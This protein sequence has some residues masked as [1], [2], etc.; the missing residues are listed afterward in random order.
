[1]GRR[2]DARARACAVDAVAGADHHRLAAGAGPGRQGADRRRQPRRG[3]VADLP[4]RAAGLR[5]VRARVRRAWPCDDEGPLPEALAAERRGARF[6]YLL[7]N[8]QNPSGRSHE[9]GAPRRARRAAPQRRPADRRGQPLRRPL[10]RRAR[11]RR[12]WPRAGREG[13][14]YLGSLLEGARAGPAARL[15][16]RAEADVRPSCC[17][18]SRRPTCTRR[19]STSASCTR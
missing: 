14:I 5:A 11:R 7:P 19:A 18:P 16:G 8:F 17:R 13:A 1:M 15:P 2:R 10:V 6:L 3:R 9:R 4:R 12:R